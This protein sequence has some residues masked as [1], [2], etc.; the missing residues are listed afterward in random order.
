MFTLL[1]LLVILAAFVCMTKGKLQQEVAMPLAALL[2]LAL[3]GSHDADLV[4]RESFAEFSRIALLFTAV[5]V[6]AHILQR[7]GALNWMAMLIGEWLGSVI[8]RL[9]IAPFIIVPATCLFT[10]YFMAALFHNTTSILVCAYVIVLICQSYRLQPLV[11][12]LGSLVA[13]NVG[14]F[15]TRFGDTPNL[16]QARI[17]GLEHKDFLIEIMPINLGLMLILSATV[18]F[19]VW[20][21][22][23]HTAFESDTFDVLHAQVSFRSARRTCHIDRRLLAIGLLGLAMAIVGP[24][25]Y[26]S[27]E[28]TL[29]AIGISLC[30]ILDRKNHRKETLLALGLETYVT[31]CAIFILAQVLAHSN[32]GVGEQIKSWL[33]GSGMTVWSIATA[34]YFGTL[35]TE[36]ASWASAASP[37]VYASAPTHEAAWALGAG[38]CAG[39]SS[40]VTAAT[41]G[42]ILTRETQ[43]NSEEARVTFRS[44]LAFGLCFSLIMLAY[45]VAVLSI[46]WAN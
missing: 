33:E 15:S 4:L 11:V 46:F 45:Y 6:P 26:P 41:A 42:I 20:K 23:H 19:L 22:K 10:T 32:I 30:V 13:S 14:G 29:S 7:A 12:L 38:I 40:L 1:L 16:T 25:I 28:I 34:S 18:S 44:Y 21:R 5:A 35:F 27:N 3:A 8:R 9:R 36:A 24:M 2:S 17:W 43:H 39:S 37:I 31:L